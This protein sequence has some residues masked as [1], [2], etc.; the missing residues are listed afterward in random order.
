MDVVPFLIL[1]DHEVVARSLQRVLNRVGPAKI[2]SCA[3]D[4]YDMIAKSKRW[5]ALLLDVFVPGG[6]G[7]EILAYC[8]SVGIDA[9]ALVMSG[10]PDLEMPNASL[11]LQAEFMTKPVKTEL[12]LGWLDRVLP[13][14]MIARVVERDARECNL[15]TI[16]A[17]ILL[18]GALGETRAAIAEARRITPGSLQNHIT[19]LLR[20]TKDDTFVS[21]IARVRGRALGSS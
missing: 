14:R 1:E 7:F 19:D 5:R 2:A 4:A 6:T 21:A 20:K 10:Q 11:S 16:E 12:V 3:K 9:P 18:S 15:T 13:E 8:R 17:E